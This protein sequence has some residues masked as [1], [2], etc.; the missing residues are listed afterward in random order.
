M[1][2]PVLGPDGEATYLQSRYLSPN[3]HKYDN[4]SAALAGRLPRTAEVRLPRPPA[5]PGL[6]VVSEGIPDALVAAQAGYR[7]AAVLGAGVTDERAAAALIERFPTERLVVAFDADGPGQA[8]GERLQELLAERGA[9]DR[10]SRLQVP[11]AA[12]DLNGWQQLAGPGFGGQLA[13]ATRMTTTT[14]MERSM[15]VDPS[16]PDVRSPAPPTAAP[17][18]EPELAPVSPER[19]FAAQ[20]EADTVSA[21]AIAA[22]ALSAP[23]VA[24]SPRGDTPGGLLMAPEAGGAL[25]LNRAGLREAQVAAARHEAAE[26]AKPDLLDRLETIRYQHVL[27]DD[28]QLAAT[29]VARLEQTTSYWTTATAARIDSAVDQ[30]LLHPTAGL[31]PVPAMADLDERLEALAYQHV[32]VDDPYLAQLN[33]DTTT[34]AVR[35]WSTDPGRSVDRELVQADVDPDRADAQRWAFDHTASPILPTSRLPPPPSSLRRSTGWASTSRSMPGRTGRVRSV[36]RRF[37]C[38][39]RAP[40]GRSLRL[41]CGGC[42]ARTPAEGMGT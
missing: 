13:Q 32:L 26:W 4:P 5:D 28:P 1:V 27:V 11:A 23:Y 29:S 2:L 35:E 24:L 12:G 10:V 14:E 38:R 37:G 18:R 21:A 8:G 9:G 15:A 42:A 40:S 20:G 34:S 7:A 33:L 41:L 6:V 3:G 16:P 31:P 36:V 22:G 25:G 17:A 19:A 30:P 39:R